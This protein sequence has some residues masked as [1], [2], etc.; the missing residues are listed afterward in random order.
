MLEQIFFI[1]GLIK[2]LDHLRE[3]WIYDLGHWIYDAG[4]KIEAPVYFKEKKIFVH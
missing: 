3:H 1:P 2:R 4:H